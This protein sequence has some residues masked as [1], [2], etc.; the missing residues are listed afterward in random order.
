MSNL[1]AM[2]GKHPL[3]SFCFLSM[4]NFISTD[5]STV[6]GNGD[7]GHAVVLIR[8]SPAY[9]LFMNSWGQAWGDGGFFRVKDAMC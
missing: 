1:I 4:C 7:G 5:G 3:K 2:V 8:C 9:L 6:K